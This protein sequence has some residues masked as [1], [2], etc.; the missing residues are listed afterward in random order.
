MVDINSEIFI[1][2]KNEV[3]LERVS[4]TNYYDD[5]YNNSLNGENSFTCK[6]P[7]N[8]NIGKKYKVGFFDKNDKF[9]LFTVEE[10][11][12]SASYGEDSYIEI[13]AVND[14]FSLRE[15]IIEKIN[16]TDATLEEC[17]KE[18]FKR[19]KYK[20]GRVDKFE[21][22][23][24]TIDYKNVIDTVN[25]LISL[26]KVEI[27]FRV[28]LSEDKTR[29]AS[30]IVDFY[31]RRGTQTNYRY[32][33]DTNIDKLSINDAQSPHFTCLYGLGAT[34]ETDKEVETDAKKENIKFTNVAWS[35]EK[36]N[37]TNKPQGQNFIL[38]EKAVE[39]WGLIEGIYENNDIK[40]P[41]ELLEKT[42]DRLQQIKEP[43]YN[44]TIT[45]SD[46]SHTIGYDDLII[47]L[48]DSII[49][50][51]DLK[52]TQEEVRVIGEKYS[53]AQK[54]VIE[55]E[56]G[57]FI[58]GFTS[59]G[60]DS[61]LPNK[62][63]NVGD[64]KP[65]NDGNLTPNTLPQIP[66]IT[67]EGLFATIKLEWT[68][69]NKYY[70]NY[71][72]H[73]SKMPFFKP[74]STTIIF[75]GQASAFLHEVKPNE[76]W[77]YKIRAYNTY[78]KY[79]KFSD[80]VKGATKKI[81]NSTQ[82]FE[83]AAIKAASIGSLNADIINAGKVKGTY[84]DAKEL[85]VT[86][87]NGTKTLDIDSYGRVKMNVT[88]LEIDSS[89]IEQAIQMSGVNLIPNTALK[90]NIEGWSAFGD[91]CEIEYFV[92]SAGNNR[93]VP[94][95]PKPP[96][97]T[98]EPP[99]PVPPEVA[100]DPVPD[101]GVVVYLIPHQDDDALTFG[102]SIMNHILSGHEVKAILCTDGSASY[103][104]KLLNDG[105]SCTKNTGKNPDKHNI[106][107]SVDGF[108][109]ARDREFKESCKA[110]GILEE[111][112]IIPENRLVNSAT[113]NDVF[114]K[115]KEFEEVIKDYIEPEW[116]VKAPTPFGGKNQQKE[117]AALGI[118]AYNVCKQKGITDLRFYIDPYIVKEYTGEGGNYYAESF[119][120][121][122]IGG[123]KIRFA[124]K[125]YG[126]WEPE[127]YF[128]SIG[129]HSVYEYFDAVSKGE[130]Y[131][132]KLA[133]FWHKPV[134]P[135]KPQPIP[136]EP[137]KDNVK[138]YLYDVSDGLCFLIK[139]K[140]K[141]T[142]I[143]TGEV[144]ELNKKGV[145]THMKN[146]GIKKIDNIIITH[147]HSDHA[148]DFKVIADNFDIGT[149]YAKTPDWSKMPPIEIE[150]KTKQIYDNVVSAL[151]KKG[152]QITEVKT[153]NYR[154]N[155]SGD[156]YLTIFNA[157][158]NNYY[159]YNNTS[160]AVKY[161]KGDKKV[162]IAGDIKTKDTEQKLLGKIGKCDFMVIA[163]HAYAGSNSQAFI[164]EIEPKCYFI[165]TWNYKDKYHS[166][167]VNRLKGMTPHVYSTD[168]NKTI[169]FDLEN[170]LLTHSA[171]VKC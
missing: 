114:A 38:D 115:A 171:N 139:E 40:D 160:L 86:D 148:G 154:I 11:G 126:I 89:P 117:H 31:H 101:K 37:P 21:R 10:C 67:T 26:F 28:E 134:D 103:T 62:D 54:E 14:F 72:L 113:V 1:F 92:F 99:E 2:D 22:A 81:N 47:N 15:S 150:W 66:K 64:S 127:N 48:G 43:S 142:L 77:F 57:N 121:N 34:E 4:N 9:Q 33:F 78:G 105:G 42:W 93:P 46:L 24:L 20:L 170:G 149:V 132:G 36:G 19:T 144:G 71:E 107:L 137:V 65:S 84:I 51:N 60:S 8:T 50:I 119:D 87:G 100:P 128:Y 75:T 25:E 69:E 59:E 83:D 58:R 5:V 27:D 91:K 165:P 68:Y 112:I 94:P 102:A 35:K 163:H 95:E 82:Y 32:T 106:E 159:D 130:Y 161:V 74:N 98:P 118:A 123:K 166:E 131:N 88:E 70:Y 125:N 12:E 90:E 143:D 133:S 17:V 145:I 124:L 122:S 73:A 53:I 80:E 29:V 151:S 79:T 13:Y 155:L 140:D 164:S 129:Y 45:S 120:Y 16:L 39:K 85:T 168:M 136:P 44:Y 147:F 96:E 146:L 152:K 138:M 156:S 153:E 3:L 61:S 41:V 111:N 157:T 162:F 18:I 55:Y 97:V 6:L 169:V 116:K 108:I 110:I 30:R 167:V 109:S 49:I 23:N 104:R 7:Y 76:T 52:D 158:N 56:F 63:G 135:N 141:V